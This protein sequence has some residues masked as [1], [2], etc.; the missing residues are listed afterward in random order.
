MNNVEKFIKC[1][2]L[3]KKMTI[4]KYNNTHEITKKCWAF[5][6]DNKIVIVKWKND[7]TIT[8]TQTERSILLELWKSGKRIK[9]KKWNR[10]KEIGLFSACL[11][12][13]E[14][15]EYLE[16][17]SSSDKDLSDFVF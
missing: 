11:N 2:S 7:V 4:K 16:T 14:C 10:E 15:E 9:G 12:F 13:Y 8:M 3:L 6:E 1:P 17:E 5:I